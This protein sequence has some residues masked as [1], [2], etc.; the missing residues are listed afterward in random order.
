MPRMSESEASSSD[1]EWMLDLEKGPLTSQVP[2]S[3]KNRGFAF[4][5]KKKKIKIIIIKNN[6]PDDYPFDL[7]IFLEG[8]NLSC[9]EIKNWNI[10]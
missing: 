2:N 8:K 6:N 3:N 4:P 7:W 10:L 1:G 9:V 5:E